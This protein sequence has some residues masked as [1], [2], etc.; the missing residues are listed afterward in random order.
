MIESVVL[1][2]AALARVTRVTSEWERRLM[3]SAGDD[4]KHWWESFGGRPVLAVFEFC[5]K[6]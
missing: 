4:P 3:K 6:G 1:N 2:N 5:K